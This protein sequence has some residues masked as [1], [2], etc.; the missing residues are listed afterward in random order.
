[1]LQTVIVLTGMSMSLSSSAISLSSFLE[2]II[3]YGFVY[4]KIV[5]YNLKFCTITMF[6]TIEL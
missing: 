3:K 4:I 6:V 2:R 1:M 5:G